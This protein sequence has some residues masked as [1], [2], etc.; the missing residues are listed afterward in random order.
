MLQIYFRFGITLTLNHKNP[1]LVIE[2]KT[3]IDKNIIEQGRIGAKW[4]SPPLDGQITRLF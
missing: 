3:K 1:K 4:S 2:S